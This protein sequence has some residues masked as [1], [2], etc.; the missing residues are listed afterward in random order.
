V[1]PR[2]VGGECGPGREE[3]SLGG[4]SRVGV[5]GVGGVGVRGLKLNPGGEGKG[6]VLWGEF[7]NN[8]TPSL[9][10]KK[11][12]IRSLERGNFLGPLKWRR[13]VLGSELLTK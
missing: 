3:E 11:E 10:Q 2:K 9:Q 1:P 8:L 5:G 12:R 4:E 13:N 6:G 7:R